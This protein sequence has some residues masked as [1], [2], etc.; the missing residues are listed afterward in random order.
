MRPQRSTRTPSVSRI[1]LTG[2]LGLVASTAMAQSITGTATFRERMALT[3]SAV[4]EAVLEDVSH[5]N[6]AAET[7][8]S[9]RVTNPGNPPIAFTIT[10]DPTRIPADH[11]YT[12]RA[13]ILL[14][15]RLLFASDTATPV[16]T[17]GNPTNVSLM[18]RRVGAGTTPTPGPASTTPLVGTHGRAIE[19][20]GK[21][22]R[23]TRSSLAP[24]VS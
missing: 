4:F 5:A 11:R 12:V 22:T 23:S 24:A 21:P 15:G 1:G 17:G 9:T 20:A 19:L 13:R 7:M 10:Y 18:L 8:A 2:L 3:P 16:I 6:A 14:D